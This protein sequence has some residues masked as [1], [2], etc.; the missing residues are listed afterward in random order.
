MQVALQH[1]CVLLANHDPL[2][3]SDLPT[4]APSIK[5][6]RTVRHH[7]IILFQSTSPASASS[8]SAPISVHIA[9]QAR[10]SLVRHNPLLNTRNAREGHAT[11]TAVGAAYGGG[12]GERCGRAEHMATTECGELHCR[13][14][15]L[16]FQEC[17]PY[18]CVHH[19]NH[20][21]S[22]GFTMSSIG[23]YVLRAVRTHSGRVPV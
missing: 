22:S 13:V 21:H 15:A 7:A 1:G 23:L 6:Q 10:T 18:T 9:L 14:C 8:A 3:T 4:C 5:L 17:P 2:F 19:E 12:N 11:S 20:G 16:S